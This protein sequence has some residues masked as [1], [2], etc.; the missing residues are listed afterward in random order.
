MATTM[1]PREHIEDIRKTKFSIGEKLN[2]LTEDL[3]QAVKNLSGEL[4]AKDVH[5]FMELVQNAE[6][7]EYSEGID[8]SLEFVITSRD[9]TAT[10]APAT[11]L[12]FNNEKGFSSKNI[13]S[14][15]SV[16]RSTKKGNRK[17]G[18][19]GEK[20]IGF[21]SVFLITAQPYIFSNG[22]QIRFSEEPCSQC[23]VGYIVP[24]WVEQNPTLSD[25]QTIYGS[26][27]ALPTTTLILPLKLDK[28]LP[29]KKQLSVI[30]P[31]VLLF[32][33]KIKRLSVR[34][35][36]EDQRQNT[37]SAIEIES[38]TDFVTR[39]NIN[40]QSY[41]LRLSA[42]ENGGNGECSYHMWKQ[43][44]PVRQEFRV[45]RRMEVDEWVITLAFPNGE[46]LRRA[47]NSSPGVYAFLPTEMVTN[48]PF[49][50]QADFLLA[51]SRETILL[52][53]KWNQGILECV[54][55]AFAHA[56]NTL[57]KTVE[58]APAS[59]LPPMFRFLPVQASSYKELNAVRESI[60]AKMI[61]EDIIPVEPEMEQRFFHKP[62]EV[63][64]LIPAFWT[65]LRKA[66]NQGV[67][68]IK[69][70]SHGRFVLSYSFDSTEY[71]PILSFLGVEPV[72]D[73][74]YV[75]CIQGTSNL[76]VGVS[77][78]VYLELLLFIAD[79]WGSK[80]GRTNMKNIPLIKCADYGNKS[81][82]SISEIQKNECRVFLSSHPSIVSW[83]IDCNREF[84]SVTRLLFMPKATQEA[85]WACS[86]KDTL[87]KW[88]ADQ[89][90][91][92]SVDVKRYAVDLL[93]NSFN[94]R[95]LVVAYAHFL[96]QSFDNDLLSSREVSSLCENMPLVDSY[97][98]V[99]RSRRGVVVPANGS[100]W[101]DL[102]DSN[103]WRNEGYVELG[104]HYISS[105]NFAGKHTPHK[106]LLEFLIN[107][108]AAVD[109]PHISAP[110]DGIS[111]VSGPLTKKNAFLLLEWIR[112]LK[113]KR[114]CIPQKFLTCIKEGSWLKVTLNGSP[115]YRPPSQSFLLTSSWGNTL[116]NGSVSVDIPLIDE[117]FYGE[118]IREYKEELMTI[119]VM[120]EYSEA[121]EFIGKHF[122]SLAA[123]SSLTRGN[124][125]SILRFIKFLRD[126]CLSPADFISTIRQGN[127][128][129]T[130][131]GYRSPVGSVLSDREWNV[132][133]KISNIPFI[134]QDFYGDEICNFRTE[135]ELLGVVISFNNSYQL[136]IDNLKSPFLIT[137]TP[138]VV[139]LMLKCMN[140][141]ESPD[142]VVDALKGAKCLKTRIGY[143]CPGECLL[144]HHEWGCILQVVSGLPVIDH[145][146]YGS[147]IFRYR[148][149]LK[150][151]G[152]AADFEEA[153]R[154]FARYFRE[155]ASKCSISKENVAS[156]LLCYRTLKGT[157][158]K[159]PADLMSC[160]GKAEW[161]RTRLGYKCPRECI[162]FSPEWKDI[163][164]IT[165]LPFIDDSESCYGRSI[166]EYR[167]ELKSL[168]VIVEYKEGLN[169]VASS[170]NLPK[171]SSRIFP[172][173]V[174]ALLECVRVLQAKGHTFLHEADF[175]KKVSQAWIKTHAGYRS[176]T[177]CLLFDSKFGLY[178]KR[179]DGPFIDEEFYG[180]KMATYKKEL[181]TLGVVVEAEQGCRLISGHL[182]NHNENE[183]FARL[184]SYL[185]AFKW[186]PDTDAA[187]RIWIPK[188][189]WVHPDECVIKDKD[190]LFGSQLTVLEKHYDQKL[191]LFFSSAF[192]V[193][194]KPTVDDYLKVWKVW[195]SSGSA[196]PHDDCCKFWRYISMH[197]NSTTEKTVA[198]AL[199]KVP[200]SSG[201]EGILLC[202][203]SD[204]FIADDLLLKYLFEKSTSESLFVW[205]PQPSLPSIPRTKLLDMY[206]KIGVRTISES[207]QKEELSLA[208][209]VQVE[210]FPREKLIKK[211]LLKLILGFLGA[212]AMGIEAD[213]R[214][215]AV[216]CLVNVTVVE[217]TKP[218]TV[219]YSLSLPN[220]ER[221]VLRAEGSRKVRFDRDN[222]MIFTQKLDKSGGQKSLIEFVTCFS[223]AISESVLWESTDHI[224]TLAEL[225]KVAALLDFNEEAVDFLM[226]FKNL[227]TFMEDEEF[228]K[229]V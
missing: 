143:K 155:C 63:G 41:T 40:A 81:L 2:P 39:K 158:Y 52:D 225:I 64:R 70:S 191:L 69:L 4:Y 125:Y 84:I 129:K 180:T 168:G 87:K 72:N 9:I 213:K 228:L 3:H 209:E 114:A 77:E 35:D 19:I 156:L 116:Q 145:E 195:E 32:L 8:P 122:M 169:L 15:C 200:V 203:K 115:G 38:Q 94:E 93:E 57:V 165:L 101:A 152:V 139:I 126:K 10:G 166:H 133:S 75:K 48:F 43:R 82:C 223:E 112:Q 54:P 85:I 142:K 44:F 149:E 24:E 90:G 29:V 106:K 68:L 113:Y 45:E 171:D 170:L 92:G 16:G 121:C 227:Q 76:V 73:D 188:G 189:E 27:T 11:L 23:N 110:T 172:V 222:S 130:S 173:N 108:A 61:D 100:K 185:S 34:E 105:S 211:S 123:S 109:V 135:L 51:S 204:A 79:N 107:Y 178:L 74:W 118:S 167:K 1:T 65:L 197:W 67:S 120:F 71:D 199:V 184:Y 33:S 217:T 140:I 137:W 160:I 182:Y 190:E 127:W 66:K 102:T 181:S 42:E 91:V 151:I 138:E 141:S 97:G 216:Q 78:H 201:S 56:F 146:F 80:F 215:K 186:E 12:V 104:D 159:F 89:V 28:V 131:L 55:T 212:P 26:A 202:N 162:L 174:L 194:S 161:L 31:E 154:V 47:M 86:R 37:V 117:S 206:R 196:L 25:I 58:G 119:G 214:Q 83:L 14:I 220:S 98:N 22:Y 36:N 95:R 221:K 136:I 208:D 193:K 218:I 205:Y 13:D 17:H 103:L 53:N 148:N 88:L 128:L 5:F 30:H 147:N 187:R 49:I 150:K 60:K 207:V 18:Y 6:D 224:D 21:K 179:T 111:S 219:S 210:S 175:M 183:A 20:G 176:P 157:S 164:P 198:D 132:A 50:I 163:S 124:V 229:T 7:N 134:D 177:E 59:S 62:R 192:G 153:A 96:Y 46:R 226:K 99:I 144:F